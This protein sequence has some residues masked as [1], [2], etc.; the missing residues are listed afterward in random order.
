MKG[1]GTGGLDGCGL[2]GT[3]GGLAEPALHAILSCAARPRRDLG[4]QGLS[5]CTARIEAEPF[6]ARNLAEMGDAPLALV[7]RRRKRK[8][9]RQDKRVRRRLALELARQALHDGLN[10][11]D[12]HNV[13]GPNVEIEEVAE[14]E[15]RPAAL[16]RAA[17]GRHEVQ[18]GKRGRQRV[19][20]GG[21]A[22]RMQAGEL[23]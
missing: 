11:E 13:R 16:R 14:R 21:G 23:R 12:E 9:P 19:G 7:R 3:A 15:A 17:E 1:H 22:V 5:A 10:A 8:A 6:D 20:S 18:T 2:R 4:A